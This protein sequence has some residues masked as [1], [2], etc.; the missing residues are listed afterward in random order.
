MDT[1][2]LEAVGRGRICSSVAHERAS[3]F[4]V[5]NDLQIDAAILSVPDGTS[6]V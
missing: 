2:S 1:S 4:T 6:S 5:V 3:G